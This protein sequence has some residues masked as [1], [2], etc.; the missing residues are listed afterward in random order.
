MQ[1]IISGFEPLC[2]R[3]ITQQWFQKCQSWPR[4]VIKWRC[5]MF[6]RLCQGWHGRRI[7]WR[8]STTSD[9]CVIS[10][11]E[12]KKS[13]KNYFWICAKFSFFF[14]SGVW[15]RR[16]KMTMMGMAECWK[17]NLVANEVMHWNGRRTILCSESESSEWF[18]FIFCEA[19]RDKL[20]DG[21]SNC[22]VCRNQMLR[23]I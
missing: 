23:F 4:E 21:E 14:V 6:A 13:Q 5:R 17:V 15:W 3:W 7:R 18:V 10:D 11:R 20:L 22:F 9:N 8:N 12:S 1:I 16:K 19:N 2:L